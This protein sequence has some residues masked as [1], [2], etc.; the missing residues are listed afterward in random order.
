LQHSLRFYKWPYSF[1][2]Q[3]SC[4]FIVSWCL[5]FVK[6]LKH[7]SAADGKSAKAV[8]GDRHLDLPSGD[9]SG[10]AEVKNARFFVGGTRL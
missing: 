8:Q 9:F 4:G 10:V 1:T 7:V 5:A 6:L 2:F 3:P